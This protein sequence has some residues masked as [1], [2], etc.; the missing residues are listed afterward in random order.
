MLI[1]SWG[2]LAV[3]DGFMPLHFFTFLVP[4]CSD[5]YNSPLVNLWAE[6][7]KGILEQAAGWQIR[8]A[9]SQPQSHLPR[10]RAGR[11]GA[12][13]SACGFVLY[14]EPI[15]SVAQKSTKG[16]KNFERKFAW[17]SS[18]FVERLFAVALHKEMHFWLCVGW[19]TKQVHCRHIYLVCYVLCRDVCNHRTAFPLRRY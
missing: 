3:S 14:T 16:R 12:S 1:H 9:L 18:E 5:C 7:C 15:Q 17:Q 13:S 8:L 19:Y 2:Q 4:E 10:Y 11:K 6:R